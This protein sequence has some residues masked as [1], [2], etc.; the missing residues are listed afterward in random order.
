[1]RR[2]TLLFGAAYCIVGTL[3][4][5]HA[6][7]TSTAYDS[8]TLDSLFYGGPLGVMVEGDSAT[9]RLFAPRATDASVLLFEEPFSV[10]K[11][12]VG[13]TRADR[14]CWA[15]RSE[16]PPGVR[17]Y[18]YSVNGP[19]GGSEMYDSTVIVAD[20]YSRAVVT[21]NTYH[22]A[23]RTL[24]YPPLEFDWGH[25]SWVTIP[26]HEMVIYET[27]VRDLTAHVS[28]GLPDSLRGSYAGLS[29]P[30]FKGGLSHLID[31][32]INAVEFLPVQDSGNLE[33]T[34]KDSS[35]VIYNT[36]NPYERNHWGY[37]T[38]YFF[39]PESYYTVGAT[40]ARGALC[41]QNGRQVTEL[42]HLIRTL[43]AHGIA[44]ILD[45]VYNH[46]SQYD[47]N[48]FKY[49]DKQYYFELDDN[50]EFMS[51]SGCGNDFKTERPMARRLIVDSVLY[52]MK[53]YHVDG[54]RFDLA[55]MIDSVTLREITTKARA[56]NPDVVL[57]AE[58]WGGG[59]YDLGLFS[60]LDWAVWNDRIRNGLKGRHPPS[61]TGF[62][63]G[64]YLPGEDLAMLFNHL[65]GSVRSGGGP[66]RTPFH[67]VGYLE[68][69][70]DHTLGDFIRIATGIMA[71]NE[72]VADLNTH[73]EI[74]EREAALHKLAALSL[75]CCQ[76]MIM[77]AEG[78]EFAR[79][80]VIAP[81]DAPDTRP[82]YIDHNSYE[83]DDETNWINYGHMAMNRDL[84]A[85]YAGL[86]HLR[87][88][89]QGL[90]GAP[91]DLVI[92]IPT[93]SEPSIAALIKSSELGDP[94]DLLFCLNPIG[95]PVTLELPEGSWRALVHDGT[96]VVSD[97]DKMIGT[98]L[99]VKPISGTLLLRESG[100][101]DDP[102]IE[103]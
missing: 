94:G 64:S 72:P 29:M 81:T 69:H 16:L 98:E 32:G 36:W 101:T 63:F 17:Y 99:T 8:V 11:T 91:A 1:M 86:V 102:R 44:V 59:M 41:G 45:V 6:A 14:G 42:K 35:A 83:K 48:C 23:A 53:E 100:G 95:D 47:L 40:M 50:D 10:P 46:V 31:L 85:F 76:G 65:T 92:P 7:A 20:P 26:P 37:M 13:M 62:I 82:G 3:L 71:S 9:F 57:I 43:H 49:I 19:A 18:G 78:Q 77:I 12:R 27:H 67:S 90:G 51:L 84:V 52:W 79:S 103:D 93:G 97:K 74:S 38:S 34:Y 28:S 39:S 22:H 33:I 5:R 70:D 87:R 68:S 80:K 55:T 61:E 73:A 58:P 56:L 96:V 4:P 24:L 89:F 54:F 60:D 30:G 66:L 25:D 15:A 21:E 88:T 75:F 2:L